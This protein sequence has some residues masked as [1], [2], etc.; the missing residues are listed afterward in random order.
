MQ[1]RGLPKSVQPRN[2]LALPNNDIAGERRKT[3]TENQERNQYQTE[4]IAPERDKSQAVSQMSKWPR[5]TKAS[6]HRPGE[7]KA[8]HHAAE[9]IRH[10]EQNQSV[11]RRRRKEIAVEERQLIPQTSG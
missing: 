2:A 10:Q 5:E 8:H 9:A 11:Y 3:Q 1:M 7:Q 4:A 6:K